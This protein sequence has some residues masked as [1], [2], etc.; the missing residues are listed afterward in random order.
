MVTIPLPP[1]PTPPPYTPRV[2]EQAIF[3]HD[4]E[5]EFMCTVPT[6]IGDAI[7]PSYDP[8]VLNNELLNLSIF[9]KLDPE[10]PRKT[11]DA[12]GNLTKG[13]YSGTQVAL[14]QLYSRI[15]QRY[16]NLSPGDTYSC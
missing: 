13:T 4:D 2:D 10:D 6:K 14:T 15:E 8:G 11:Q 1:L 12:G 3:Q 16:D 7:L 5:K 9:Q